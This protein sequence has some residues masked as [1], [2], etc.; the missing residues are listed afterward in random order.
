[1][2]RRILV[3]EDDRDIADLVKLVLETDEFIVE[4][5]LD[6]EKAFATAKQFRPDGILLDLS[7]PK[8]DGWAIFKML[9]ADADFANVPVAILT[10]KAEPFDEMV[11]LHVMKAD[12][13]ITIPF[14]K[15]ELLNK[16][17]DLFTK[18]KKQGAA[19]RR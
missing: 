7:M 8:I 13:Y 18:G 4:S 19:G 10:A 12:G 14:G 17:H 6:P 9:R 16:T 1:M 2:K 15:Q 3:I 11:G 5:V